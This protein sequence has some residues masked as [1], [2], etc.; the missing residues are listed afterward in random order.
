MDVLFTVAAISVCLLVIS[1]ALIM[2]YE[3]WK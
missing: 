1:L 2:I 3:I